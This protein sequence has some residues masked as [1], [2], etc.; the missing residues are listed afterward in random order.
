[1]QM[2]NCFFTTENNITVIATKDKNEYKFD[3]GM[4]YILKDSTWYKEAIATNSVIMTA[5]GNDYFSGRKVLSLI[6]AVRSDDKV[7]GVVGF[8]WF[9]DQMT[10]KNMGVTAIDTFNLFIIDG[11]GQLL[12]NARGNNGE[13]I[14][15]YGES[16]KSFVSK[17]LNDEVGTGYYNYDGNRYRTF[18]KKVAGTNLTLFTSIR[19]ERLVVMADSLNA[20]LKS[21]NEQL[22]TSIY[23]DTNKMYIY[24]IIVLV[25]VMLIIF[26]IANN[27][28][29]KMS[30]PLRELSDVLDT[31][32]KIQQNML[33]KKFSEITNRK[34]IDLYAI[35]IPEAEVGGDFYNYIINGNALILVI[36]DVS[37]SGIP[38]ALFMARANALLHTAIKLSDSPKAILSYVNYELCKNNKDNYFVTMALYYIDLETKKVISA[39][40]GHE[41]SIIIKSNGEVIVNKENRCAPLGI[42]DH[43]NYVESEFTLEPDDKLF[44]YTDGVVEAI[45]SNEELYGINRLVDNLKKVHNKYSKEIIDYVNESISDYSKGL[46]QYDDITMLCFK[47][48]DIYI[49]ER[50]IYNFEKE[51]DA[52]Y[53]CIDEIDELI[54]EKLSI[55]YSNDVTKFKD[56]LET[57]YVCIEELI[58]NIVDYAYKDR[59]GNNKILIKLVIDKNLDKLSI[60]FIDS[61]KEFDPTKLADPNILAS[62]DNRKVGGLGVYITKQKMDVMEYKYENGKN[63]LTI[64][65]YL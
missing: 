35:N 63:C 8:D 22:L 43:N 57:I 3:N 31:A 50:L 38:A 16:V 27:V 44:L 45:N 1:M 7:L 10:F 62:V 9:L 60:S 53:E 34:D 65:K 46:E 40:S 58:V 47:I 32:K 17:A 52:K 36:A 11:N 29:K 56:E 4:N 19:D 18:Y 59:E 2:T 64:T 23:K 20:S 6:K 61:G 24:L 13:D 21:E 5:V 41:D 14:N 54:K 30:E 55:V 25:I 49:D 12:F 51:F 28:S 33:P 26:F 48:N 39:N 15:D 37:G 42:V